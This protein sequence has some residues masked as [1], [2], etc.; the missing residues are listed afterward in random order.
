MPWDFWLIFLVLGVLI[1]WRGRMRLK[2]LL[3]MPAVGTKEKLVLYGSTIA[4][5]W[6]LTGV[7]AWRSF[8][9]GL[10]MAELGLA[11]PM[12]PTLLLITAAGAVLISVYQ[13]FSLRRVSRIGDGRGCRAG[14]S[15]R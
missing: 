10:T 7:V 3:A 2:H 11:K 6:I 15:R 12:T 9:R 4:F 1:P 14:F 8:A 5:Q 13:W